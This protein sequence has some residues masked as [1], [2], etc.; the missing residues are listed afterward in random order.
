MEMGQVE[1]QVGVS[2]FD[3]AFTISSLMRSPLRAFICFPK[4]R[5][6]W[7]P[8]A[9]KRAV[10]GSQIFNLKFSLVEI[11]SVPIEE[12]QESPMNRASNVGIALGILWPKNCK[13][14]ERLFSI[15][16]HI[17]LI[18]FDSKKHRK[19]FNLPL[20]DPS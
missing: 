14:L 15:A 12:K 17:Y 9:K 13:C 8:H 6:D 20:I 7:E 16:F 10:K 19:M 11:F 5:M 1:K 3:N 18:P 2:V 4:I